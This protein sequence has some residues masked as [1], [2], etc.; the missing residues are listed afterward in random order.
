MMPMDKNMMASEK[1]QPDTYPEE[2]ESDSDSEYGDEFSSAITE[3]FPD[4]E[5][6]E[7]RIAAMKEAREGKLQSFNS[8]KELMDD[9]NAKD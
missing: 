1:E 2:E 4:Q 7:D 6:T 5:W 8:V 9:L 3:A